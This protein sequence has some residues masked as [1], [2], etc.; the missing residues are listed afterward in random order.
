M[1]LE[2]SHLATLHSYPIK[3]LCLLSC[4][5]QIR[6]M[7]VVTL[8][9]FTSLLFFFTCQNTSHCK[10]IIFWNISIQALCSYWRPARKFNNKLRMSLL[11]QKHQAFP[12]P[13]GSSPSTCRGNSS[14]DSVKLQTEQE[15]CGTS[16]DKFTGMRTSTATERSLLKLIQPSHLPLQP[17]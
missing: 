5:C 1:I 14:R 7:I 15:L 9:L 10:L 12:K 6:T 11:S 8:L 16:S 3:S 17:M 13:Q 4:I 2:Q